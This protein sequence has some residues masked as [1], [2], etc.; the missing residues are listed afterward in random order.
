LE[1][2]L[3]SLRGG[4]LPRRGN[5]VWSDAGE[6][7]RRGLDC[8]GDTDDGRAFCADV[9]SVWFRVIWI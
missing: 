2:K 4:E 1:E 6:H 8:G 3:R 7:V 9:H 5:G